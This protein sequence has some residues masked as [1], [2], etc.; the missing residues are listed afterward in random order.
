MNQIGRS[1]ASTDGGTTRWGSLRDLATSGAAEAIQHDIARCRNCDRFLS[2]GI[3]TGDGTICDI[4]WQRSI[5]VGATGKG[6][7]EESDL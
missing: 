7:A 3:V 2:L 5:S 1:L 4:C 6:G